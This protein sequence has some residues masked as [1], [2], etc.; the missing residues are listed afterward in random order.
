M[1]FSFCPG[2]PV[3]L[4]APWIQEAVEREQRRQAIDAAP[5]HQATAAQQRERRR[6]R[7]AGRFRADN[8][9]TPQDEAWEDAG[10]AVEQPAADPP[11]GDAVVDA[12]EASEAS[13]QRES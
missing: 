10:Q 1:S 8:P 9:E 7:I 5:T 6:A 2:T 11:A 4:H 3:D 13:E 12:G